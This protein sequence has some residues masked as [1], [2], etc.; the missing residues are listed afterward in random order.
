M[1]K[2]EIILKICGPPVSKNLDREMS[3]KLIEQTNQLDAH[4]QD[5][6]KLNFLVYI[7][8]HT[9]SQRE[10]GER[11]RESAHRRSRRGTSQQ[12]R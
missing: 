5:D 10:R 2:N 4:K 6:A 1:Y 8:T 3:G 7:H 12:N 9:H 11:E